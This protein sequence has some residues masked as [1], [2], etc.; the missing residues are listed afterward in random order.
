MESHLKGRKQIRLRTQT[1]EESLCV[2][3]DIYM[4]NSPRAERVVGGRTVLC[5]L[6]ELRFWV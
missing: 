4:A 5:T 1:A 2:V 6:T 3:S